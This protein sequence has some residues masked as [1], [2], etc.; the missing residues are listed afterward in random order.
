MNFEQLMH[1]FVNSISG[2]MLTQLRACNKLLLKGKLE[3]NNI[4]SFSS[5]IKCL[6]SS[7]LYFSGGHSLNEFIFPLS[8]PV[9][10]EAF[11]DIGNFGETMTIYG[12]FYHNNEEAFMEALEKSSQYN[13]I[14]TKR[15]LVLE[16]LKTPVQSIPSEN[17]DENTEG[18]PEN[19][20]K[21]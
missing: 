1:P 15:S 18:G 20:P 11:Q 6:V 3:F 5:F 8:I 2:T 10:K 9:V 4:K 14:M 17:M 12:L 13:L 21:M 19:S 7:M 16:Q